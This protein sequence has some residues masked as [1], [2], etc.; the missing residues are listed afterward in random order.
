MSFCP[1]CGN[2]TGNKKFCTECGY[3]IEAEEQTL[4]HASNETVQ[5]Q[6]VENQQ[7]E[8]QQPEYQQ[9]QYQQPTNTPP[10]NN[11]NTYGSWD[12]NNAPKE[13]KGLAIASMVLGI[14]GILSVCVIIGGP[15]GLV[16]LVLGIVALVKGTSG[17][18]FAVA[19][20]VLSALTVIA[21]I[22]I[23][24][25]FASMDSVLS[26]YSYLMISQML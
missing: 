1:K 17:P 15:I 18:G 20:I 26:D 14:V 23:L 21:F 10:Y 24:I 2:N 8:Y 12:N 22:F 5:E 11:Q 19:G 4:E 3:N 13:G 6:P 25:G 9:P 7:S 16:G